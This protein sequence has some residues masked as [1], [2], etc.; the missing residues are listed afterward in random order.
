MTIYAEDWKLIQ[1][2]GAKEGKFSFAIHPSTLPNP[3]RNG[4][5]LQNIIKYHGKG[6]E[7]T[8]IKWA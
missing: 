1:Y 6:I 4:N 3:Q 2:A 5:T 7:K 8:I